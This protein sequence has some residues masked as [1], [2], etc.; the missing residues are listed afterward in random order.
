MQYI[1]IFHSCK[2]GN[3][4]MK[5][6]DIFL[7]FFAQNIDCGYTLE[8]PQCLIVAFL[9]STHDLCFRVKIRKKCKTPVLLYKVGCKGV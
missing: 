5:N 2:K 7:L 1:A 3:F 9:S 4:Q 6:F 8:P